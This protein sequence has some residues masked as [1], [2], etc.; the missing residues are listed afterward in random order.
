MALGNHAILYANMHIQ[1]RTFYELDVR[2]KRTSI[3][4]S[5]CIAFCNNAIL[6]ANMP[7]QIG[8]FHDINNKSIG[9]QQE[10]PNAWLCVTTQCLMQMH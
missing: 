5:K 8:T 9:N 2:S 10:H 4:N 7:N 3:V 6:D 1:L